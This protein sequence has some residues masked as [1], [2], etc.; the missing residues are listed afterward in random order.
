[1][2]DVPHHQLISMPTH[3]PTTTCLCQSQ[4]SH[5]IRQ[6]SGA[7][8]KIFARNGGWICLLCFWGRNGTF[9]MRS[10]FLGIIHFPSFLLS[11][12]FSVLQQPDRP[13]PHMLVSQTFTNSA[14]RPPKRET[15]HLA[16]KRST[17]LRKKSPFSGHPKFYPLNSQWKGHFFEVENGLHPPL[18]YPYDVDQNEQVLSTYC[19]PF[20]KMFCRS[21]R[22]LQMRGTSGEIFWKNVA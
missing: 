5:R 10:F 16:T 18:G 8:A 1:M 14:I 11:P 15:G 2:S 4:V 12:T 13:A 9:I 3:L 19:F 6:L 22:S 20:T 21:H 7:H 17:L